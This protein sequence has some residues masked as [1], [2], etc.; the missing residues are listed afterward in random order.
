MTI[1]TPEEKKIIAEQHLK[2]VLFSEYNIT[3]SLMES[4]A[5]TEKNQTNIDALNNQMT[6]VLSQK[7]VLQAEL[8]SIEAEITSQTIA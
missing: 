8:D 4:N 6:E 2:T 5:V 3:L 1:L 7:N